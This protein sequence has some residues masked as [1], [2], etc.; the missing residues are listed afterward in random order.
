ME[1]SDFLSEEKKQKT[2]TPKPVFRLYRRLF[3][4]VFAVAVLW[5]GLLFT[6]MRLSQYYAELEKS[7]KMILTV[8]KEKDEAALTQLT[9]TLKGQPG[10]SSVRLFS[11]QDGLAE[12]R[13]QNPQLAESM[14]LM[15]AQ[16][17]PAYFEVKLTPQMMGNI[18]PFADN[19]AAQYKELTLHYNAQ[20]AELIFY[21]GLCFRLLRLSMAFAAVL[22]FIFMFLVE[23]HPVRISGL[24]VC[25]GAVS[26]LLAWVA[27]MVLLLV[28]IYPVGILHETL[29]VVT[30]PE[31]QLVGLAFSILLGWTFSKWQ[32]F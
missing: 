21:T 8:N 3:L 14:L 31:R 24:E 29:A 22:F 4:L 26:G 12:V 9:Q 18:R 10:F 23:A 16:K 1:Q 32:K 6:D 11:P 13:R 7:F 25:S 20:H 17:M 19:L 28:L 15:G 2:K 5:Q 30:T 27:S